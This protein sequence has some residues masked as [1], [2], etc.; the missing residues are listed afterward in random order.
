MSC[1]WSF[2]SIATLGRSLVRLLFPVIP[3]GRDLAFT[4]GKLRF[5]LVLTEGGWWRRTGPGGVK[6]D[7]QVL[8]QSVQFMLLNQGRSLG[9]KLHGPFHHFLTVGTQFRVDGPGTQLSVLESSPW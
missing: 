5:F 6:S 2:W 4:V 7:A 3:V 9:T 8:E 1:E